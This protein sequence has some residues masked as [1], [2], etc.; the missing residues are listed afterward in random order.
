MDDAKLSQRLTAFHREGSS[1]PVP[2]AL[3]E[4]VMEIPA[5]HDRP[6]RRLRTTLTWKPF[7]MLST[8]TLAAAAVVVALFGGFLLAGVLTDEPADEALP[9]AIVQ[10]CPL[11]ATAGRQTEPAAHPP[12]LRSVAQKCPRVVHVGG[13]IVAVPMAVQPAYIGVMVPRPIPT[14]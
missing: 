12:P 5:E 1:E 3:R 6:V 8:A 4:A 10:R 2:P 9:A 11:L 13:L 7:S 14:T